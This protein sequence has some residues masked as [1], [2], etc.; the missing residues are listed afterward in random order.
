MDIELIKKFSFPCPL[1]Q[2]K[3]ERK[4]FHLIGS[5]GKRSIFYIV[6]QKCQTAL[7]FRFDTRGGGMVGMGVPTDLGL[8][9][10][11]GS[12]DSNVS[13]DMVISAYRSLKECSGSVR[14][15]L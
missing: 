7:L 3:Y 5:S 11:D 4:D 6:C 1:C 10:L 15:I 12:M 8:D 9:E 13:A 14:D 2:E